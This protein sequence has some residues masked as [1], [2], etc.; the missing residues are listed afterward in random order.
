M[1]EPVVVFDAVFFQLAKSGIA[2]VWE[3]IF[4]EWSNASLFQGAVIL[5]RLKSCPRFDG[6]IYEDFPGYNLVH[7][8]E[9]SLLLESICKKYGA[10]LFVS[11]YY[12]TPISTPSLMMVYDMIPERFDFD[13]NL[14]GW[15]EKDL[16]IRHAS[17]FITISQSTANDLREFYPEIP[18]S[19]VIVAHCGVDR[20]LF[21]PRSKDEI[22]RFRQKY[23]IE[24]EYYLFVGDRS[25]TKGYKNSQLFFNS[26]KHLDQLDFSIV[27]VG[28]KPELEE[29]IQPFAD[30][31]KIHLVRLDDQELSVAYSDAM[32]LVYPSLYEGFGLPIVE[33]MACGC[34][35]I[36]TR[37]GSIPEAAGAAAY[38]ISG[39]DEHEMVRAMQAVRDPHLKSQLTQLGLDHV[40]QFSWNKMAQITYD[41]ICKS[42]AFHDRCRQ[43]DLVQYWSQYRKV[44]KELQ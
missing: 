44:S 40:S 28:G 25:Q 26:L 31:T 23:G 39:Q 37:E 16:A 5:D 6:F 7:T 3:S 17:A 11:T 24:G 32:A 10:H 27:C 36:T 41:A 19:S 15:R 13:L 35:V 18:E 34:P 42:G 9:D 22:H 33:A 4:R 1:A 30:Q 38:F 2:R 14:R 21:H 43:P 29:Y 20:D 8:S 12:T